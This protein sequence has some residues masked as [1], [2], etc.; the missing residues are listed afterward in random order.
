MKYIIAIISILLVFTNAAKATDKNVTLFMCEGCDYTEANQLA[1]NNAPLTQ[2]FSSNP[3]EIVTVDN[4]ACYSTPKKIIV[5]DISDNNHFAFM[6][7]HHNQGTSR[8]DLEV[9][10]ESISLTNNDK[11]AISQLKTTDK[12]FSKFIKEINEEL[13]ISPLQV[14]QHYSLNIARANTANNCPSFIED[15]VEAA[16]G[17]RTSSQLQYKLNKKAQADF[18]YPERFFLAKEFSGEGFSIGVGGISYQGTWKK[19]SKNFNHLHDFNPNSDVPTGSNGQYDVVFSVKWIKEYGAIS[20][21]VNPY[22]TYLDGI[23]LSRFKNTSDNTV[24]QC[25]QDALDRSLTSNTSPPSSG[26]GSLPGGGGS[27]PGGGGW[28]NQTC[29]K[30]YYING[31]RMLTIR[32]AC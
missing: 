19:I 3:N 4:Q 5:A 25:L 1:K 27:L 23:A 20:V 9:Y 30:H 29:E 6:V 22:L 13:S 18:K 24:S 17:G 32:V 11:T 21:S 15:A 16:F 8:I 12:N 14:G 28:D 10:A 31:V 26:G 2:C 7:G